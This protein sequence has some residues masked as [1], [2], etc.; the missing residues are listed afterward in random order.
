M[1]KTANLSPCNP[2]VALVDKMLITL[3]ARRQLQKFRGTPG[4]SSLNQIVE[5]C[6]HNWAFLSNN[7]IVCLQHDDEAWSAIQKGMVDH[8]ANIKKEM[9]QATE[10]A[11]YSDI[12]YSPLPYSSD[13]KYF[14]L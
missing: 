10:D 12:P 5:H 1:N 3:F 8:N 9:L 14:W 2:S 4:T 7:D 6:V 13:R 11:L